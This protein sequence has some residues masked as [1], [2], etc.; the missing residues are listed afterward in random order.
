MRAA[1]VVV[2]VL[3]LVVALSGCQ[4]MGEKAKTG[5]VA[6]GLLGAAAG[7]IIGHQSGHGLEGAAI[8]AGVGALGGALVGSSMDDKEQEASNP[9]YLSIVEIVEMKSKGVPDDVIVE[10]IKRTKS[11]YK[12]SAETITYL[13]N[14]GVGDKVI[15]VMLQ[16]AE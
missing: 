3:C 12:L 9:E 16:G 8:G 14:N 15:D 11:T 2:V 7:G 13:K 4:S 6:G 1:S 10:E 5:T